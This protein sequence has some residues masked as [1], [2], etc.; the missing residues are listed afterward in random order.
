MSGEEIKET[1]KKYVLQSWSKQGN[2]NPIPVKSAEGIY[3]YDFDGNRYTDMASQLVNLNLGYGNKDIA[4]AIKEQVDKYCYIGPSLGSEPRA[5][6]AKMIID[7]LPDT[8]GKVFFT[9]AGAD[10]NENAIKIA[11]MFTGRKKIFSR[12][13]SYHGSSFGAGNLTGEPRRYPLE[14]GIP[15][16]VKFFDPYIYR[17]P[18][19]FKSEEEATN[20]YLTKLREQIIYEGPDSVAAIVM[21]TITGSNGIIIPPKGYLPGVRKICDEFGIVMICDE[22]MAGWCRTGKM[23]AFENF[24]VVPDLVTFAK[25]VTCGYVQLGGVAVSTKIAEYFDDNMLS[26][27]LTYSGHPL[28]CAA[29]VACVNYYKKANILDNV[30]S[31]GEVLA[32]AL[33]A[34]KEKHPCVGDVRHIGLFSCVELV[35]DKATK[36]PLVSYGKDPEGKMGKIIGMLKERKFMTYSHENMVFVCPPLIITKEQILEELAK[37]DEVLSIVDSEI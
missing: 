26:C 16:F 5:E 28:A 15:G 8:F 20:Y 32:V 2:I 23:F 29:G 6:L 10:A 27:G 30:N 18:I 4:D 35:K 21:E 24:D 22:V 1:Q 17:E 25:G 13:R 36:E 19:E 9:N 37:L 3:Y 33:E 31:V 11:R 7:L 12:Y 34:L 14:P